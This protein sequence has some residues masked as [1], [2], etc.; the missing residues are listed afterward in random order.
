[1][2]ILK[3]VKSTNAVNAAGKYHLYKNTISDVLPDATPIATQNVLLD[4]PYDGVIGES[5]NEYST[6]KTFPYNM[7]ASNSARIRPLRRITE[8]GAQY[9]FAITADVEAAIGIGATTP[10]TVSGEYNLPLSDFSTDDAIEVY[11][12][13]DVY[14]NIKVIDD[15]WYIALHVVRERDETE[16]VFTFWVRIHDTDDWIEDIWLGKGGG[17]IEITDK[18]CKTTMLHTEFILLNLLANR[19]NVGESASPMCVGRFN[20]SDTEPYYKMAFYDSNMKFIGGADSNVLLEF[21]VSVADTDTDG[22]GIKDDDKE[23]KYFYRT[24]NF[25]YFTTEAI[26]HIGSALGTPIAKTPAFVVFSAY[27]SGAFLESYRKVS[28]P[29]AYF[30]LFAMQDKFTEGEHCYLYATAD[31][32]SEYFKE[33]RVSNFEE[34]DAPITTS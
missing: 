19:W 4:F 22:D 1:M 7:G 9:Y 25:V 14:P 15:G 26:N 12:A 20:L 24:G 31:S 17:Y 28:V 10:I 5:G 27:E 6:N 3:Y 2:A 23:N 11:G 29:Y 21:I 32:D 16:K 8:N 13:I 34:Y 33:S 18:V 30:P